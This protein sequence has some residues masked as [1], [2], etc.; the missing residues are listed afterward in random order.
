M[1]NVQLARKYSNAIFEIAQEEGKLEAYGEE[2]KSVREGLESVP[3]A[4]AF[5]SNPQ[6]ETKTKKE[7]LRKLFDGELSKNVYHFL[8]LLVDKRRFALLGAIEDEYHALSNKARGI[9]IADVTTASPASAAQQKSIR[10]KLAKVTGKK[11]E[12]RLHENAALIGGVVVRIGDRR[13]DGSVAGR[14]ETMRKELL[15]KT[16]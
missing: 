6:I 14:L 13:I 10:E 4:I 2:L 1:L 16:M 7:L 12:L 9:L 3:Q 5:L 15:V 11:V 8:L